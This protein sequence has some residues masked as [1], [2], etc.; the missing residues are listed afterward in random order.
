MD[1]VYL[2]SPL[3]VCGLA[4]VLLAIVLIK[5]GLNKSSGIF[6]LILLVTILWGLLLFIMRASS[7]VESAL[8]WEKA[9]VVMASIMFV[10]YYYFSL[11][12][13][14]A[15]KTRISIII[16]A[17]YVIL[18]AALSPTDIIVKDMIEET[19]GYAPVLGSY[20]YILSVGAF[21][22]I[23]AFYNMT[24][25]YKDAYDYE[26]KNRVLF[27]T[28]AMAFPVAGSIPEIFPSIPP[29]AIFG[30]IVFCHMASI[31]IFKY[32]L[33][34]VRIALQKGA[35][36]LLAIIFFA[37]PYATILFLVADSLEPQKWALF[38]NGLLVLALAFAIQPF[39]RLTQ[40]IVDRVCYRGRYDYLKTLDKF[41]SECT[42][43][44]NLATLSDRLISITKAAMST[45]CAHLMIYDENALNYTGIPNLSR[46]EGIPLQIDA[47]SALVTWFQKHDQPLRRAEI[48]YS[49]ELASVTAS[50]REMLDA[51]GADLLVPFKRGTDLIGILIMGKRLSGEPYWP[52]DISVLMVLAR[53]AA[54]AIDNAYLYAQSIRAEQA[55]R[56]SEEKYRNLVEGMQDGIFIARHGKLLFANDAFARITGRPINEIIGMDFHRFVA[57]E[58]QDEIDLEIIQHKSRA[59]VIRDYEFSIIDKDRETRVHVN[60]TVS[61]VNYEGQ[62]VLMGTVKDITE[63]KRA[64]EATARAKALEEL[65]SLRAALLANVSHELRTPLTSIKGIASTLIQPDVAWD[66]ATQQDFLHIINRESD[67]LNHIVNDLIQMSQL[68]AGIMPMHKTECSLSIT[69]TNICEQLKYLTRNHDFQTYIPPDMPLICADEIRIGE[70]ITNLVSNAV[71]YSE[72]GTTIKLEARNHEDNITITVSDEGIGIPSDHLDK[73]FDRFYRLESGVARRRGGTG[74]GLSICKGI[75]EA[76][77]GKIRVESTIGKG[78]KFS[79]SLPVPADLLISAQ[80]MTN[81]RDID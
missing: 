31:A 53:H 1:T 44:I 2:I 13:I 39:W 35:R 46:D 20:S 40:G 67:A 22:M 59:S 42:R 38:I 58:D 11:T 65:D 76:H 68:E 17:F 74:L 7:D 23:L 30:N 64:E 60:M 4:G 15:K 19:Y 50:E 3:V 78:S 29:T 75:V 73:I 55:L 56:E 54:A 5:G 28:I 79:F 51:A 37:V 72:K 63:R 6:S 45:S 8:L 41:S 61:R 32:H 10:L 9:V 36:Y 69:M 14:E 70:V 16:S 49:P 77:G 43:I 80:G 26:G 47:S 33:F 27:L 21:F 18:I 52:D 66:S 25:A 48:D 62:S 12:L 24:K 57:P 71:S 34:D 81:E